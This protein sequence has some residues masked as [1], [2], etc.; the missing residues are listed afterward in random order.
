MAI[1]YYDNLPLEPSEDGWVDVE[2]I[3]CFKWD[4]FD[5]AQMDHLRA[6]FGT[7][8]QSKGP[9]EHD[10]H[11]WFSDYDDFDGGYLTA[12][13]EPPGLQ[14]FGS[15]PV[16]SWEEWDRALQAG[17]AGLPVRTLE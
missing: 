15:L 1:P 9:D 17:A 3:Y 4:A 6:I 14:V 12:G 13:V 7:L 10:C 8:P 2:R 16:P 5:R 11:W